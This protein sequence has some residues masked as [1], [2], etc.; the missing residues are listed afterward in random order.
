MG[1]R[2]PH[3]PQL[4][5]LGF[6]IGFLWPIVA[7]L[8]PGLSFVSDFICVEAASLD[9][10]NIISRVF[11]RVRDDSLS[12]LLR[13]PSSS[14][15]FTM[16]SL[17]R[18]SVRVPNSHVLAFVHKSVTNWSMGS[19]GNWFLLL[20]TCLSQMTF[21]LGLQYASNLAMIC[22]TFILSPS[23]SHVKL[24]HTSRASAPTTCSKV[25]ACVFS[26]L[27]LIP[28]VSR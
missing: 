10:H 12:S 23:L 21:F 19:P 17:M 6:E 25:M 5:Y 8:S 20:N 7:I 11:W 1:C 9:W 28:L 16:Q 24:L 13:I 15:P 3:R 26:S 22:F 18:L 4:A 27:P 14:T 2:P